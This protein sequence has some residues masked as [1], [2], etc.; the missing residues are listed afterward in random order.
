MV[1]YGVEEAKSVCEPKHCDSHC[2]NLNR[3]M[4]SV[5]L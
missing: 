3:G 5:A 4:G 2:L 1:L